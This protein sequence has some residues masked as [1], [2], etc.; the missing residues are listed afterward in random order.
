MLDTETISTKP[1]ATI[2]TIAAQVFDP[3]GAGVTTEPSFYC[4]VDMESQSNRHVDDATVTWWAGQSAEAQAEAFSEEERLPLE[5]ALEGLSKFVWQADLIWANGTVF[6]IVILE[7]ALTECNMATP[8]KFWTVR[9]TR[10]V[11]S[12]WPDCPKPVTA[13]HALLDCVRQI[14][15]LQLT[16][17]TLGVTKLK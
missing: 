14:E 9:D 16:L 17:I 10:T 13:H 15:M 1:N 8:W 5:D 12:L 7:N 3:F 2:L 11:Y 4:R 6:D